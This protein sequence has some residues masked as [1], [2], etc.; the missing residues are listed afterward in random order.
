MMPE[1][2]AAP[3]RSPLP[4]ILAV[5]AV[6]SA[7]L[8]MILPLLPFYASEFGAT[9][10]TIGLLLASFSLCELLA[11]PILGKA[12][13]LF[14]RKRLLVASQ[15][16]TCA[17]FLLLA[18]APN[19]AVVFAARILG[20]LSAGNI[21]IAT[22]Y[23][24]DRTAPHKRRQA[25]GFVSA[26]MGVG[27]MVGPALAGVLAPMG[28]A[29]PFGVAAVVSLA[30]ILAT[31]L[32]LPAEGQQPIHK[33]APAPFLAQIGGLLALPQVKHLLAALALLFM[34]FSLFGS[35]FAL[36]LHARFQWQGRPFDPTEIGFVFVAAGAINIL[37]QVV[38]MPLL[39]KALRERTLAMAS[40][41]LLAIGFMIIGLVGTVPALAAGIVM[42][43]TG[44]AL[45]RPTLVAALSLI[46]PATSQGAAMGMAQSMAA[47]INIV[48]PIAG[49]LLIEG[50]H[51]TGWAMALVG[52]ALAGIAV[53]AL[54]P[55]GS[56]S[57][58]R[59]DP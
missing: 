59:A 58:K 25:I 26:A 34:A 9:P 2:P 57:S 33:P 42:A 53:V 6:E 7:G 18:L 48:A 16:G 21:S 38:V 45:A 44:I 51:F 13:D 23:V 49:G 27:T 5:V 28:L 24:S 15:I 8:G 10:L 1:E 41:S 37:V 43:A 11:A 19:L 39:G 4:P 55:A 54:S 50:Q 36:V 17:S 20:G 3:D 30:S 46:V 31:C 32:L 52:L 29:V 40:F 56:D 47:L 35:Q 12:S 14:G 22:A